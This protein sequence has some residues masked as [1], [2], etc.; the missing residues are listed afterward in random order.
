[1]IIRPAPGGDPM[2]G[3]RGALCGNPALLGETLPRIVGQ[4]RGCGIERPVRVNVVDGVRLSTPA[5]MDCDTANA[6]AAWVR[7]GVKPAVGRAGGGVAQLHVAAHYTCRTRNHRPGARLS[8]HG[9]GRAIDISAITLADGRVLSV[10]RDWRGRDG[11][12][13][14]AM[15]K[16]ACGPFTTTLGPGSDGMHEDHL[17]LDTAQHRRGR[18][19]R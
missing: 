15:H 12:I 13:L 8:E 3:T 1:A 17:H 16:S 10:L 14:K 18:Y 9:R 4:I 7:D 5:T 19:C 11:H 6:L 2:R